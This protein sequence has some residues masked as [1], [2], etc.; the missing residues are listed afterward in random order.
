MVNLKCVLATYKY[1]CIIEST[2]VAPLLADVICCLYALIPMTTNHPNENTA[3]D[4]KTSVITKYSSTTLFCMMTLLMVL[5]GSRVMLD[6]L[7]AEVYYKG[8]DCSNRTI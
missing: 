4:P 3:I 8:L 1:L 2:S 5:N 6:M 7:P